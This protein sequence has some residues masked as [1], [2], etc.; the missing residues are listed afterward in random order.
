MLMK[1]TLSQKIKYCKFWSDFTKTAPLNMLFS[2]TLKNG[3]MTQLFHFWQ[4][5]SKRAK[6]QPWRRSLSTTKKVE[7]FIRNEKQ[8]FFKEIHSKELQK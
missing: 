7:I 3:Q 1:L 5:V 6:R 2:T 8:F 4:T